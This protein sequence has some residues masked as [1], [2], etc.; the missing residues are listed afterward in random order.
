MSLSYYHFDTANLIYTNGGGA[1]KAYLGNNTFQSTF[2]LAQP[3]HH[4]R[5]IYLKSVEMPITFTNI[6]ASNNTNSLTIL[7]KGVVYNV[8]LPDKSYS[9]IQSLLSDIN[10]QLSA[11]E[12]NVNHCPQF[13][14]SDN[15]I[16]LETPDTSYHPISLLGNSLLTTQILG[17]NQFIGNDYL[18][19]NQTS[20]SN[21]MTSYSSFNLAYDTYINMFLVN[22]PTKSTSNG[23]QLISFKLP[24]KDGFNGS[25]FYEQENT[26]FAQCLEVTDSK[27]ILSQV[28][29]Q[30]FDRFGFPLSSNGSQ[31]SFTLCV[32][33]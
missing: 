21:S 23:G 16:V 18:S 2:Q 6:R 28:N 30:M 15:K 22:V 32:E 9:S 25:I 24:L 33:L 13:S 20:D 11:Q 1:Q 5:K 14:V 26:S 17:F 8:L 3:I 4:P 31:W 29:V 19:V 27:Y 7:N 10:S 12:P